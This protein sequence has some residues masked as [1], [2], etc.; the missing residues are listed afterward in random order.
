M[1]SQPPNYP[2][3]AEH[4]EADRQT[5]IARDSETDGCWKRARLRG[6]GKSAKRLDKHGDTTGA[7]KTSANE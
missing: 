7:V 2:V 1:L 4:G 5:D 3:H 6:R